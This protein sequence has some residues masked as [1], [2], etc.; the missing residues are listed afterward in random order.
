MGN[1][2]VMADAK[3]DV[4]FWLKAISSPNLEKDSILLLNK[5]LQSELNKYLHPMYLTVKTDDKMNGYANFNDSILK[6]T[7]E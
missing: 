1:L 4:D 6:T 7:I 3:K 5:C 2:E